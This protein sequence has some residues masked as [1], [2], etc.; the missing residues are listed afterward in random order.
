LLLKLLEYY[1]QML[2]LQFVFLLLLILFLAVFKPVGFDVQVE[3]SYNSVAAVV[4]GVEPPKAKAD[5]CVPAPAKFCLAVFKLPGEV[6]QIE[7]LYSSV[8]AVD[9]GFPP[10]AKAACLCSCSC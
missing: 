4:G 10:K 6:A 5:V 7:P 8:A 3:P 9:G 2:N 1:H